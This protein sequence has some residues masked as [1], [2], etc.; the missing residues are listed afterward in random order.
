MTDNMFGLVEK[1]DKAEAHR[2]MY[3]NSESE[4]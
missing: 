1:M 3:F 4:R 2:W